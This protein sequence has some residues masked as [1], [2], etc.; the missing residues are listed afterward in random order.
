VHARTLGSG[1]SSV[2]RSGRR[3]ASGMPLIRCPE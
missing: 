2:H 3:M 1:S